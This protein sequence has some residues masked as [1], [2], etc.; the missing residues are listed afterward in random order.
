M[1]RCETPWHAVERWHVL[2]RSG[3]QWHTVACR[4]TLWHDVERRG[5]QWNDGMLAYHGTHALICNVL[6]E[7][8]VNYI[9]S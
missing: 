3:I 1:A 7:H 9:T 8:E 2:A 6:C 5:M 4:G